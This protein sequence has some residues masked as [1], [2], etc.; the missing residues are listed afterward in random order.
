[1]FKQMINDSFLALSSL[2]RD[3]GM[4]IRVSG[5]QVPKL[6]SSH[7]SNKLTSGRFLVAFT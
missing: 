6:V 5:Q 1:M 3:S 7:A 2:V 4:I